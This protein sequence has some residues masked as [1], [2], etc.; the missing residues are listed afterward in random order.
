MTAD[1]IALTYTSMMASDSAAGY[2]VLSL[3]L[4]LFPLAAGV[5]LLTSD[6]SKARLIALLTATAAL[7]VS[8]F[9]VANFDHSYNG[10][11][12]VEKA[13]WIPNLNI[14][15]I[16]G[17]DGISVLFLPLTNLLFIGIILS[18]WTSIRSMPRLFYTLL[19]LLQCV[20]LG[21]FISL[22]TIL[23]FLF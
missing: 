23:F 6:Q 16:V 7:L 22:N 18:S 15:Y 9:V 17:I 4:T 14:D 12:F 13:R 11:Q 5:I 2:P 10:F 19:L 20:T 21:I 1:T 8:L 3:L